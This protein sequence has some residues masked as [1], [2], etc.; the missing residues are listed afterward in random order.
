MEL[1]AKAFSASE[2]NLPIMSNAEQKVF[3]YK[4]LHELINKQLLQ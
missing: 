2:M 1:V 3:G 4:Q